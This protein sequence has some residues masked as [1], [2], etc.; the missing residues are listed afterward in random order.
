M[1]VSA[2]RRRKLAG[3]AAR[4]VGFGACHKVIGV[5]MPPLPGAMTPLSP[6][7]IAAR[8]VGDRPIDVPTSPI[9]I[10]P[11]DPAWPVTY[12]AERT[13]I[14]AVLGAR[15]LAVEHVGSTAVPGLSAKNRLD[16]DLIV[17]DP[18][19]EAAYV[20][21][22]ETAGYVLR[23]REPD[24][25]Q[26]RCLWTEG[27]TVNLHVFGSD[28]DEHLRHLVFRD[29]LRTHPDDRDFYE[30]EKRRAAAYSPWS[31]STYNAQK[32]ASIIE[33]LRRAGLHP[34]AAEQSP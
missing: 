2:A 13:R 25:Y 24:W 11:Y 19:D 8:A 3:C 7:R 31:M 15:A 30:A 27:H 12:A 9:T 20:P 32:A 10:T 26:H 1:T 17:A 21:A 23:T 34:A 28:C 18:A 5:R 16:I 6:E 4:Q 29:W 14:L 22:L 33:I